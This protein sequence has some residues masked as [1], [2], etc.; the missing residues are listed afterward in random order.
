[1]LSPAGGFGK[2]LTVLLALS[3]TG[4]IAATFYSTSLNFQIIFPFLLKVPRYVFS[5]IATAM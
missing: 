2:F 5:I 4:N 3:V 1:M